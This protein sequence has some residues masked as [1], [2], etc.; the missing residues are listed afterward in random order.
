M[1]FTYFVIK[2]DFETAKI[3]RAERRTKRKTKFFVFYPE[4]KPIFDFVKVVQD[5]YRTK[6]KAQIF[7]IYV[8][9]PP[10]YELIK[11]RAIARKIR[12][13]I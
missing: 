5:M 11:Y 4:A 1:Y 7:I 13:N 8:M 9:A 6:L 3:V 12:T 2:P 10:I